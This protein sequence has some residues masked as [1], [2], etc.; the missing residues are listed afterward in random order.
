MHGRRRV[1]PS[2]EVEKLRKEKEAT[3]IKE[4]NDLVASCFEKRDKNEFD[5]DAFTITTKILSQNP[6]F[7]TIWN[8]R[9]SIL[10]Y[11]I[12]KEC[13][14]QDKQQTL[15]TELGFL[16]E[17]FQ[18]N[19]K[20]YW[21]FNHRRWCLEEI[22]NPDWNMELKLIGKFLEMDARNFHAW[23]YRRYV[24]FQLSSTTKTSL[25]QTEFD[26]TT[27][28]INQNFS[29]YSAWHQRSKLM[30]RLIKEQNLDEQEKETLVNK[31]F[32]LVKAAFYTDPDDQSAWLYHWWLVGRE[33]Q[34]ISLL[35]AYYNPKMRQ[36]VLAFDDE[37]GMVIP[38]QVTKKIDDNSPSSYIEGMWRPA[39]G[40]LKHDQ[41][42]IDRSYGFVWIFTFFD[43][44]KDD[45]TELIVTVKPEFIVPSHSEVKLTRTMQRHCI[46]NDNYNLEN[47]S[48]SSL[49]QSQ[50]T[51]PIDTSERIKLLQREI[52][53]VRELL[54]LE[55]DTNLL[56]ELKYISGTN[57][58][59]NSKIDDEVVTICDHLI[60]IDKLRTKRFEDLRSKAI[61]ESAT[62]SLVKLVSKEL[63]YNDDTLQYQDST[64]S[65]ESKN[66]TIIPTP[67]I[68][69]YITKLNL[70]NNKLT[71]IQFLANLIN[72]K[73]IDVSNNC[74]TSISG[75]NRLRNLRYLKIQNNYIKNW[76]EVKNGFIGWQ[77]VE[78]NIYI[79]ENPLI[80]NTNEIESLKIGWEN[81]IKECGDQLKIIWK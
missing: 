4:Y 75:V 17:L 37:I 40:E 50:D 80:E 51:L 1:K 56:R 63:A 48:S 7:Y 68:L 43:S 72:L 15:S 59:E 57:M 69:L 81:E 5:N 8:F 77:G 6:D 41:L 14:E 16:Q 2:A 54:E 27:T 58:E 18:L 76:E 33:I 20:S 79:S 38:F 70:S 26:F 21:I 71:S 3:K 28:K 31:E 66:L 11:G 25:T 61:F 45:F 65:L 44:V 23:D 32:E 78:C 49:S 35:G 24:T 29:N 47:E 22:P 12:L 55:P 30:P 19:P 13:S 53:M 73:E 34:H 74:I 42:N 64:F 10:L 36:V 62:K 67:S 46:I 39:G 9:R 60:K 52:S